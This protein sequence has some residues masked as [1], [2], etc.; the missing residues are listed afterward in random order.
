MFDIYLKFRGVH[1]SPPLDLFHE[2]KQN[3]DV[4]ITK[5]V[6]RDLQLDHELIR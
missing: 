6:V 5:K 3:N 1:T 4:Q 2:N